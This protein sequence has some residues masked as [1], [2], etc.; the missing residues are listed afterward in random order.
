MAKKK[1]APPRKKPLLPALLAAVLVLAVAAACMWAL[2]PRYPRLEVAGFQISEEEYLRAMYQARNDIL[3]D[4]AAAGISLTDWS[5]ETA[6]GDP[7]ALTA[8]RALAIL[9]EY[10]AT[11]TLAVERGYL[12]DAGYGTMLEDMEEINRKRQE[13]AGNGGIVTGITAFSTDDYITYRASSLRLQFCTDPGN[14]EYEV[15]DEEILQRYEADRDNLYRQP[16]SM[17]LGFLLADA[18]PGEIDGLH[19]A[20]E[21]L[22]QRATELGDLY[23]ALEEMPQL[24]TYYQQISVNSGTYSVYSRSHP[25]VLVCAEGLQTGELSPVFRMENRLC[26]VLCRSRT[27]HQYTPLE[28][29]QSMVAQSIRESRYDALIEARMEAMEILIDRNTLY[30]YTAEQLP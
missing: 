11:G 24:Q 8:D 16:D 29:V 15:T 1:T 9:T 12:R 10:Y 20:F 6:L 2:A 3:S 28:A 14:P 19:Q 17:E 26:L 18:A 5:R 7:C 21:T 25:D 4:H 22:H 30:R 13:S 23:A 27:V